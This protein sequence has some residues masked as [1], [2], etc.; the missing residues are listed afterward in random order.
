M[1]MAG[2][3]RFLLAG[4]LAAAPLLAQES[5][6]APPDPNLGVW[7]WLNFAILAGLL[8]WI[9]IKQGGPALEARSKG[10]D[11]GL[12]AGEKAKAE[13]EA[14][15]A[16]V[17]AKLAN[18]EKEIGAMQAS[19]REE[20]NREADR[21]RSDSQKEI[22]RI[23]LQL[24]QETQSAAKMARLEVQRYAAKLAIDLAEQKVRARMTPDVQSALLESFL[25]DFPH[26][27]S[28][29]GAG[30]SGPEEPHSGK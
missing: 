26:G 5:G 12:A 17:Q 6:G 8:F 15:A 19:A 23:Q 4:I 18:L 30:S 10:I 27:N 24:E 2:L 13:A 9:A 11:E 1:I 21:I 14:R 29:N 3:R 22:A 16:E 25:K 20:R 28:G 7:K